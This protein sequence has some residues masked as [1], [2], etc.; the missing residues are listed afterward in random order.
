[1]GISGDGSTPYMAINEIVRYFEISVLLPSK[2]LRQ[3]NLA[4]RNLSFLQALF[5]PKLQPESLWASL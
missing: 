5:R 4:L 3:A 2:S 1:M